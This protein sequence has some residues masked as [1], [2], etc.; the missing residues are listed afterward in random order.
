M[1]PLKEDIVNAQREKD[2]LTDTDEVKHSRRNIL[3]QLAFAVGLK[4][5]GEVML[6]NKDK[7]LFKQ[8]KRARF[9]TM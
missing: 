1:K 7:E 3:I 6:K 2:S 4:L 5:F 8:F 9:L